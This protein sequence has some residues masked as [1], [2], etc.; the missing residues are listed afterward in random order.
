MKSL[1]L[2]KM[3]AWLPVIALLWGVSFSAHALG[4]ASTT[5]ITNR[6]TIN[7]DVGTTAQTPIESSPAGNTTSG[8]GNGT[9]TAFVVDNRVDLSLAEV[10]ATFTTGAPGEAGLVTTFSL[11][12]EGNTVQDYS[13][14]AVNAATG[15]GPLFGNTDDSDVTID[16]I[17]VE[18][19]A[20]VGY[21]VGQDTATFVDELAADGTVA[22][23]VLATIPAASIDS[24]YAIV[25]LTATTRDGGAGGQGAVTTA[26]AGA[27]T[28]GVDVVLAD[29]FD[30]GGAGG[31]DGDTT[32]GV[33]DGAFTA[34]DAYLVASALI[35]V[36]KTSAVIS[37]PINLGVNPKRIPG[38]VVR[39][40]VVVTNTG[41]TAAANVTLVDSIPANTTYVAGT[42]TLGGA[43]QTDVGGDDASDFNVT[44]AGAV[45]SVIGALIATIGTQTVTFDVTVN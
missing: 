20:T 41:G 8:V 38:A 36:T 23:Y 17:F 39:Y 12:N 43:A 42:I 22:V 40:T 5:S 3:L 30:D 1:T 25:D 45:T 13:F 11:T 28:A 9:D 16:N 19:G 31:L 10:G 34:Q 33:N 37:D 6:A 32:D 18:S 21:Q 29:G 35:T 26:T 27:D 15:I 14:A 2:S 7:Y 4:T 44:N 24:N